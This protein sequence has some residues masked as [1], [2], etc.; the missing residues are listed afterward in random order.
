[1]A[2]TVSDF[3]VKR[4]FDWA[5]GGFTGIP[6]TEL[7]ERSLWRARLSSSFTGKWRARVSGCRHEPEPVYPGMANRWQDK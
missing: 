1:M 7:T 2:E 4:S 3:P 5:A 6:A